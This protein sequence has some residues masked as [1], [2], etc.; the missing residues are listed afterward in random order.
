MIAAVFAMLLAVQAEAETVSEPPMQPGEYDLS[1]AASEQHAALRTRIAESY[2]ADPASAAPTL[3]D[4]LAAAIRPC[5]EEAGLAEEAHAP[6][7]RASLA[8]ML[9]IDFEAR[10]RAT[11]FDFAEVEALVAA[12]RADPDLDI[13]AY[14]DSRSHLFD[15]KTAPMAGDA[16]SAEGTLAELVGGYLGF[17]V[18]L[19]RAIEALD[20]P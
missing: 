6:Y 20:T 13:A 14:I 10:I 16:A 3:R 8:T 15:A 4:E 12:R 2:L 19:D 9:M 5:F 11:G 7:L 1:C 18:Q 17:T